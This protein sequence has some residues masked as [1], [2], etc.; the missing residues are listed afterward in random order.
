MSFADHKSMNDWIAQ[1]RAQGNEVHLLQK[2]DERSYFLGTVHH[3]RRIGGQCGLGAVAYITQNF[4]AQAFPDL[5][6]SGDVK[7][8]IDYTQA[9]AKLAQIKG[10]CGDALPTQLN[11]QLAQA[12]QD[13][14]IALAA[15]GGT[16]PVWWDFDPQPDKTPNAFE[17]GHRVTVGV[18]ASDGQIFGRFSLFSAIHFGMCFGSASTAIASKTVTIDINPLAMYPP[19][20]IMKT[21]MP[22]ASARVARPKEPTAGLSAAINGKTQEAVFTG[23]ISRMEEYA[24]RQTAKKMHVELAAYSSMSSVEGDDL[25]GRVIDGQ[26]QRAWNLANWVILNLKQ[27]LPDPMQAFMGPILDRLV[28]RDPTASNGLSDTATATLQLAKAALVA[29]L[30]TDIKAGVLTE[31]RIEELMGKGPGAAVVGELVLVPVLKAFP[32]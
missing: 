19:E 8:F 10:G 25:L 14:E 6:R 23:L 20:D 13:L 3:Q 31:R 11:P 28:A 4:M 2:A 5:A 16:V 9:I 22:V 29:Q 12:Q 24:L 17:F 26:A 27:S 18:D 1:Q 30:R 32:N 21:E 15:W 7:A